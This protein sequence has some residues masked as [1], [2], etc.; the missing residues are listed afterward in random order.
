MAI[1]NKRPPRKESVGA[2]FVCFAQPGEGGE[3][4]GLFEE[5]VERTAV[6]KT[7]TVTENSESTDV[8]ASGEV[9]DTDTSVAADDIEVEVVAFPA[10]TIARMRAAKIG[11]GGLVKDGA[12]KTRPFFAYGKIVMLKNGNYRYEW[13]PKCKL[14]QNSD[15]AATRE[16]SS[17]EQNDTITISAYGFD[18]EGHK[19]N[20]V[21]STMESFPEGI[22][23]DKF[24]GKPIVTDEDLAS[25][26]SGGGQK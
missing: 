11:T 24:F 10:D 9:Y 13:Y 17:S 26:I 22:T 5:D 20:Y 15:E 12:P 14:K 18:A 25:A 6:V 21:D 3:W 16:E 2:Q 19:K 1:K 4:T 8:Y 7:V 23:E